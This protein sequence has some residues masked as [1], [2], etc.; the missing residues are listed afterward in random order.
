MWYE[1]NNTKNKLFIKIWLKLFLN[2]FYHVYVFFS[3]IFQSHMKYEHT[4]LIII[5]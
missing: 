2:R 3:L 5:K 4:I 1:I